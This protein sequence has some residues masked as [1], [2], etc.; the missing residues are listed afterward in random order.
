MRNAA[1]ADNTGIFLQHCDAELIPRGKLLELHP[2]M[3]NAS[4]HNDKNKIKSHYPVAIYKLSS[5]VN[6]MI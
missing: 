6:H 5:E 4:L 3:H 1:L 2:Q